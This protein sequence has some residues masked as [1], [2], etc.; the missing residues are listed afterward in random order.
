MITNTISYYQNHDGIFIKKLILKVNGRLFQYCI[1]I[2]NMTE[3]IYLIPGNWFELKTINKEKTQPYDQV[4]LAEEILNQVFNRSENLSV[5]DINI[6]KRYQKIDIEDITLNVTSGKFNMIAKLLETEIRH[7]IVTF[8][9][10]TS[11]DIVNSILNGGYVIPGKQTGVKVAHGTMYGTGVYSSPHLDK[12][13]YYTK[14]D[15]SS[16]VYVLINIVCL[17]KTMLIPPGG[18]CVDNATVHTKIV[19]GL[20]QLI[21][22]DNSRIIPVGFF[23]IK[24]N[25]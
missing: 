16:Y 12:T 6:G 3:F 19:H 23:K 10:T 18:Q 17:G 15:D 22:T 20:D 1:I 9:G 13:L 11:L 8:H 21:S 14:M 5:I 4:M 2:I 24:V 25:N 7:P